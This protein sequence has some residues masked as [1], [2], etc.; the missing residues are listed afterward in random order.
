MN[1]HAADLPE[2]SI[3]AGRTIAFLKDDAGVWA[4][5]HLTYSTG[6]WTV[7]DAFAHGATVLRY[8]YDED[9]P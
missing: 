6:D 2:G 8:G 9:E 4:A 5:T 7:D 1:V 3:V